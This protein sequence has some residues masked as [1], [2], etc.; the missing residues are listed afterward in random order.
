VLKKGALTPC[1][2]RFFRELFEPF[3]HFANG[4]PI[5]I[6]GIITP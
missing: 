1:R 6:T 4:M 5:R 2:Q 3:W